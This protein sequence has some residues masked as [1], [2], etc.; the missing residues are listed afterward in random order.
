MKNQQNYW[1]QRMGFAFLLWLCSV[2]LSFANELDMTDKEKRAIYDVIPTNMIPES[3]PSFIHSVFN[4]RLMSTKPLEQL[5][6]NHNNAASFLTTVSDSGS[7]FQDVYPSFALFLNSYLKFHSEFLMQVGA[8]DK[9]KSYYIFVR[10]AKLHEILSYHDEK[11]QDNA[12]SYVR[13]V[14]DLLLTAVQ[15]NDKSE[16][17]AL[18]IL[19]HQYPM[20]RDFFLFVFGLYL[21]G[22]FTSEN[23]EAMRWANQIKALNEKFVFLK[24]AGQEKSTKSFFTKKPKLSLQQQASKELDQAIMIFMG[25]FIFDN[26]PVSLNASS[27]R[28][29]L[30]QQYRAW[31]NA[32]A[33]DGSDDDDDSDDDGTAKNEEIEYLR[34]VLVRSIT[35]YY[36][37]AFD[38]LKGSTRGL[39]GLQAILQDTSV[40]GHY[41]EGVA[42]WRKIADELAHNLKAGRTTTVTVPESNDRQSRRNYLLISPSPSQAQLQTAFARPI[43]ENEEMDE[44]QKPDQWL[45]DH[46]TPE[47]P[48]SSSLAFTTAL[49]FGFSMLGL[50]NPHNK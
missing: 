36:K 4:T 15:N 31:R 40:R 10:M 17:N 11:N 3:V 33:N 1:M 20:H 49:M 7:L 18:R 50:Q 41:A 32:I 38:N 13:A 45:Y 29:E 27:G 43:N 8:K 16:L 21:E 44:S 46:T 14:Q 39:S 42:G 35:G 5:F 24:T 9:L 25:L 34:L 48:N 26:S 2:A 37:I 12:V 47:M 30:I 19:L 6:S 23:T 22:N 28:L